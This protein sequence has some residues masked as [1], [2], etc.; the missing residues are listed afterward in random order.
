MTTPY[1]DPPCTHWPPAPPDCLW[2]GREFTDADALD[3]TMTMHAE[4]CAGEH[5]QAAA[6]VAVDRARERELVR[7]WGG[8]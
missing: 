4:P 8:R 2:C 1:D 7:E 6:E 3:D 5:R